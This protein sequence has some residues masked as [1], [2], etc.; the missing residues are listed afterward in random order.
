MTKQSCQEA[1]MLLEAVDEHNAM[2]VFWQETWKGNPVW[3]N[4]LGS[5]RRNVLCQQHF[6]VSVKSKVPISCH[7]SQV[8]LDYWMDGELL[9]AFRVI[10]SITSNVWLLLRSRHNAFSFRNYYLVQRIKNASLEVKME[11]F[12]N[13]HSMVESQDTALSGF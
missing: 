7:W 9:Q 13:F 8:G 3:P 4:S 1:H 10:P 5:G 12:Q 2:T 11:R 6:Y